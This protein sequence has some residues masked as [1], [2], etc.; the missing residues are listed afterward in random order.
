MADAPGTSGPGHVRDNLFYPFRFQASF[1]I[2]FISKV[3]GKSISYMNVR[4][5]IAASGRGPKGQEKLP[6]GWYTSIQ[7]QWPGKPTPSPTRP[8]PDLSYGRGPYVPVPR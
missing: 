4:V 6:D 3:T 1:H 2:D 5:D 8:F 7:G